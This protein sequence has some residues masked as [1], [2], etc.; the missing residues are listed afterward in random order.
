MVS[1]V[2]DSWIASQASTHGLDSITDCSIAICATYYLHLFLGTPPYHEPLLPALGGLTG[3]KAHLSQDLAKFKEHGVTPLFVFDGQS[4]VGQA[5]TT[6]KKSRL[7]NLKTDEAWEQYFASNAEQAVASFGANGG[8]FPVRSLY[9]LLM[10]LLRE[11]DYHFLVA[12]YNASA[13]IA[14]FDMIDSDQV[15]GIM[16]SNE[17]L[18]YPISDCV[19]KSIDWDAKEITA[20]SKKSLIKTL[21]VTES[22]FVDSLLMSGTAFLPTFPP[23]QD[24]SIIRGQPFIIADAINMLRTSDK[25]VA[26]ACAA[27]NDILQARDKGWQDKYQRARM[28]VNHMIYIAENGE[29]KVNDY[30][31]LTQDNH[32]YLGLQLPAELFHYVNTGLISARFMSWITH[33]QIVVP[34]TLDGVASPEYKRLVTSQLVPIREQTLGLVIPRL[35]RGIEHKEIMMKVWFDDEFLYKTDLRSMQPSPDKIAATWFAKPEDIDKFPAPAQTKGLI[36]FEVLSLLNEAFVKH[37]FAMHKNIRGLDEKRT[38]ASVVVWR[39]LHLRGYIDDSHTLTNWGTALAS[40]LLAIRDTEK[41]LGEGAPLAEAVLMAF[42][43]IRYDLLNAKNK[44]EELHGLPLKGT[45][46]DKTSLVLISRCAT[47]LKLRHQ[48]VGYTGPLNKNLLMFRSL[49]AA[50]REANRDLVEGI[51]ASMFINGQS[52]RDRDD[53]LEIGQSLPFLYDPD[54]ALGI[55]VKTF[56]DDDIVS[57]SREKRAARLTEFPQTYV[58]FATDFVGDMQTCYGFV[59]A[60]AA[61]VSTLDKEISTEDK[62]VW[63]RAVEY[64]AARPF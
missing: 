53:W 28:A 34:P 9:P 19:I 31:H 38:I 1:L 49:S 39:F 25:T 45:E 30:E 18:L 11:Q 55:A 14:Y 35:H 60:I 15:G 20:V 23:L 41:K 54:T 7:A 62:R 52:N 61:G 26:N 48:T 5:E 10:K 29:I 24:P 4:M 58:P 42:E 50:V 21:N 37:T 63:E 51:V 44:H 32:E 56:L 33:S 40:S 46:E 36:T 3:I 64:L 12:P 2:E 27:F 6:A 16:G 8:A 57:D 13:Q 43:L 47:L 59:N 22:M 17:L